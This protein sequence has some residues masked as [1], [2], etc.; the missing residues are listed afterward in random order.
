MCWNTALEKYFSPTERHALGRVACVLYICSPSEKIMG[1]S[2]QKGR[3]KRSVNSHLMKEHL[4]KRV[5]LT[6]LCDRN[7]W[8]ECNV[9]TA[10]SFSK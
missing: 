9:K 4:L 5:W 6:Q 3:D 2:S 10:L 7:S 8:E 1:F